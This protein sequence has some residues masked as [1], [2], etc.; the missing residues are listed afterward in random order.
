MS[1]IS[2]VIV[3]HFQWDSGILSVYQNELCYLVLILF[4]KFLHILKSG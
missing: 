1:G 2:Y 4:T 3:V